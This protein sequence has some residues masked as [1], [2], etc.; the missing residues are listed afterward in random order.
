M[1]SIS[2]AKSSRKGISV[3]KFYKYVYNVCVEQNLIERLEVQLKSSESELFNR[4]KISR[5]GLHILDA[6]RCLYDKKRT[7]IFLNDID[8]FVKPN[9]MV[10]EAGLGTGVLAAYASLKNGSVFGIEINPTILRL[11]KFISK[12][13][14]RDGI[15]MRDPT[16]SLGDATTF[17]FVEKADVIISENIYTGMFFEKQVQIMDHLRPYLKRGGV[18][19]PSSMTSNIALA[20][21]HFKKQPKNNELFVVQEHEYLRPKLLSSFIC[22]DS[23][24]FGRKNGAAVNF[25]TEITAG[26]TGVINS[27]MIYSEVFMPSGVVIKKKTTTFLNNEIIIA[28]QANLFVK[29]GDRIDFSLKYAYGAKPKTAVVQMRIMNG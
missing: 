13:L 29:K 5:Q 10:I 21:C 20:Q 27:V 4:R 16:L 8:Q 23:L 2:T 28:L 14:R 6:V 3:S 24:D 17:K 19:I 25:H 1:K 12:R 15:A 18:I 9:D 22:Y 7:V 26:S 11:A